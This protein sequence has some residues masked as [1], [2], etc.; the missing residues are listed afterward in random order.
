MTRILAFRKLYMYSLYSHSHST[1]ASTQY[2]SKQRDKHHHDHPFSAVSQERT[3]RAQDMG[4]RSTL[5]W[6]GRGKG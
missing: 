5:K 2:H 4:G 6:G 3:D 1:S